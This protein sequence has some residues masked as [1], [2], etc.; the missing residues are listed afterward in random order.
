MRSLEGDE[1][2]AH[3]RHDIAIE[4]DREL[5]VVVQQL[6]ESSAVH[7]QRRHFGLGHYRGRARFTGQ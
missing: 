3:H 2:F 5:P 6:I 4:Q 1:F 7:P